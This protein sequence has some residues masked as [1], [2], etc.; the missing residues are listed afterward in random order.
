[1]QTSELSTNIIQFSRMLRA[2]GVSTSVSEE[3][4]ALQAL[5]AID[6]SNQNAFRDALRT[7]FA[8]STREIEMFEKVFGVFFRQSRNRGQ[9]DVES[10]RGA[11]DSLRDDD[12]NQDHNQQR[13]QKHKGQS[14]FQTLSDW[15]QQN[16]PALTNE[17]DAEEEN[18]PAYSPME[19]ITRQDFSTFAA[20]D[21]DEVQRLLAVIA[22]SITLKASRRFQP[23][24]K[25]R[26][27]DLRRTVRQSLRRSGEGVYLLYRKRKVEKLNMVMLCDVSKSM[28]VYSTFLIQFM[29]AFQHL[30]QR[31]ETFC[32][33][34]SLHHISPFLRHSNIKDALTIIAREIADWSGGTRIGASLDEFMAHHA[35]GLITNKTV[36]LIL[37]DGWDTGE[38]ETLERAMEAMH[39]KAGCVVWLNPLAGSSDYEPSCQGMAAALPFVD[40]F[41]PAHNL[42]SLHALSRHLAAARRMM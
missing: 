19:V 32:F 29:Y 2:N 9:S 14:G 12:D 17:D 28:D 16:S 37:S 7:I 25:K 22:K 5:N 4:D 41:A 34:T 6:L 11:A 20:D 3:M 35:H 30:Y 27:A 23:T 38:I 31:L 26:N 10:N 21:V 33:A 8:K 1:M 15:I 24:K 39:S 13:P 40:I 42:E 36:V 18:V